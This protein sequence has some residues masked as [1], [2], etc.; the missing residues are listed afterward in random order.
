MTERDTERRMVDAF[1]TRFHEKP[2]RESYDDAVLAG[3]N[4]ALEA[5]QSDHR[6]SINLFNAR[7]DQLT[8]LRQEYRP[9]MDPDILHSWAVDVVEILKAITPEGKP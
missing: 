3:I 2:G 5:R 9:T 7:A 6:E 1:K 8:K 4:A